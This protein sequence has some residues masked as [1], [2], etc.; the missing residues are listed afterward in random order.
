MPPSLTSALL[1]WK[2]RALRAR[3][4]WRVYC[5]LDGKGV[6]PRRLVVGVAPQLQR[7]KGP[8][9]GRELVGPYAPRP[10]LARALIVTLLSW[11]FQAQAAPCFSAQRANWGVG[12][13]HALQYLASFAVARFS[14][15]DASCST[16][17]IHGTTASGI[18]RTGI[19]RC[20]HVASR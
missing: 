6:R 2:T 14:P 20:L 8:I 15:Q 1:Y 3:T 5:L 12:H 4:I 7:Q 9:L 10:A 18:S 17:Q 16:G 13:G 11:V 19:L